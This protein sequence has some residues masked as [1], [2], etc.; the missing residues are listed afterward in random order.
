MAVQLTVVVP[1]FNES[2]TLL[3]R[4]EDLREY[5]D[6]RFPESYELI[7]VDDGS[8]D[9][10]ASVLEDAHRWFERLYVE[11]H[12]RN[13][14]LN[15]AVRTGIAAASGWRIVVIDADLTYAP[16]T[17]GALYD[18]LDGGAQIA[19]ASA[20]MAGGGWRAVPRTRLFISRWANRFLSL[21]VH[22]SISTLTCMVRAYDAATARALLESGAFGECTYGVLL[23]A[24][25]RGARIVELPAILDWSA[26]PRSR[27]ARV[28]PRALLARSLRVLVAG[29]RARPMLLA[30]IPGLIPGVLPVAAAVAA[31]LHQSPVAI[32][33]TLAITFGFQCLSLAIISFHIGTFL[34]RKHVR[35][36]RVTTDAT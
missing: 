16:A 33:R 19:V 12:E 3:D 26:Q 30:G 15:A 35:P 25:A 4:L 23:R 36:I 27:A 29:I 9:A 7:V 2:S 1:A 8:T 14:G 24:Y 21:A 11:T 6:A 34:R 18:A 20:Y 31:A 5:L 22:G 28:R 32:A 17:I 10:T 13:R